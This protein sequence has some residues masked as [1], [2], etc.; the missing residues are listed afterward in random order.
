ML[1]PTPWQPGALC[2]MHVCMPDS[3][4]PSQHMALSLCMCHADHHQ[5][6]RSG[7]SLLPRGKCLHGHFVASS[8][9]L[10]A[11]EASALPRSRASRAHSRAVSTAAPG[12]VGQEVACVSVDEPGSCAAQQPCVIW[13]GGSMDTESIQDSSENS[14]RQAVSWYRPPGARHRGSCTWQWCALT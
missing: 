7:K 2:C 1:L 11:T 12:L 14:S 10:A 6:L 13:A 8:I 3:S 9:Q 4:W 5:C